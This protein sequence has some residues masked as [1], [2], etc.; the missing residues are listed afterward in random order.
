MGADLPRT[1]GALIRQLSDNF[2]LSAGASEVSCVARANRGPTKGQRQGVRKPPKAA[3]PAPLCTK[4]RAAAQFDSIEASHRR[5]G[6]N[7]HC[8]GFMALAG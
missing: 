7:L 8:G 4:R 5:V 6:G 1:A 2:R 3:P